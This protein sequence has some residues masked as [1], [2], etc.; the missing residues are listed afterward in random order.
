MK[1][2]VIN[3]IVES[4]FEEMDNHVNWVNINMDDRVA[5]LYSEEK[6]ITSEL[7]FNIARTLD[8]AKTNKLHLYKKLIEMLVISELQSLANITDYVYDIALMYCV[9]IIVDGLCKAFGVIAV[10]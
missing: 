3:S 6:A 1:Y 9:N 4:T 7:I 10:I 8:A 2:E 5:T